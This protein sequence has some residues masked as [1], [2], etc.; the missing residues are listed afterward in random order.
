MRVISGG[1][2]R[3]PAPADAILCGGFGPDTPARES[4]P[5]VG[6][7][8][9]SPKPGDIEANLT[10]AEAAV[11]EAKLARPHLRWIVLPELFTCAYTDLAS[12]SEHAE[13]AA[14]GMSVWRFS[15]L[16]HE[17]G[18]YLAYGFP[19]RLPDGS[20]ANSANLVG[21]DSPGPLLTYRKINLVET[22]PGHAVFTPGGEVPVALADGVRVA[23]VVCWDL[24]HP[25]TV[26]EAVLKG[27]DVILSPAAWRD[28]WGFQY[29]LS[30]AARALD[31]GVYV[32]SANQLGS[33]PEAD[34]TEP[35]GVFRPDGVRISGVNPVCAGEFDPTFAPAW[36]AS[37]GDA[38]REPA[39]DLDEVCG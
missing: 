33:Y 1:S 25:E 7:L 15:A 27:A 6:S 38:R 28:P 13:D 5:L 26:R 36:R 12:A 9:L 34:F 8:N 18:V 21:P 24:G 16:A 14:S 19:E 32:A 17:L 39:A 2:D 3:N 10:L 31:N 37:Y 23:L 20:V 4:L 29:T 11:R 30:C 22:T 35:G